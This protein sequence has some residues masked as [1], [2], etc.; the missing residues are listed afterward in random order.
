MDSSA[1]QPV[2]IWNVDEEKED[3]FCDGDTL[4]DKRYAISRS[5]QAMEDDVQ[6]AIEERKRDKVVKPN[7]T[8][9][10]EIILGP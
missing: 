2:T 7:N 1:L 4:Y 3:G 10:Y 6:D 5:F 9:A 8:E